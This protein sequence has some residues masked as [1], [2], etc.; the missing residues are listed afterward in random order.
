MGH[1]GRP[2]I[3]GKVVGLSHASLGDGA[4]DEAVE[5]LAREVFDSGETDTSWR[6]SRELHRAHDQQLAG[7]A[8]PLSAGQQTVPGAKRDGGFIDPYQARKGTTIR[9]LHGPAQLRAPN[10]GCLHP[11]LSQIMLQIPLATTPENRLLWFSAYREIARN[12]TEIGIR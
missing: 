9:G 12:D 5:R 8:S 2:G 11:Q 7:V 1:L 6:V 10:Q 4:A 3:A